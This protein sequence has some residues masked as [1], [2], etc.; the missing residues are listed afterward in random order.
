MQPSTDWKEE[1]A[2]DEAERFE[3]Y[4]KD[5]AAM[6]KRKSQ[7][8]GNGRALHRKQLQALKAT[9]EVLPDLPAPA[10]QGLFA[11]AG[12]HD[13]WV[14]LSNGGADRAPNAKPDIRGFSIKVFGVS[15]PSALGSGDTDHQ[16]FLLINHSAFAFP[17]S[18]EF[19]G[20]ALAASK[21]GTSLLVHLFRRYGL[22]GALRMIGIFAGI[23]GKPFK[24]FACNTFYSAAPIACGPYAVR[25]RLVPARNP[26]PI[27]AGK[28]W[29]DDVSERLANTDLVFDFQLQFFVNEAETPIE[30]ASIDWEESVSPYVTVARLRIP[31]QDL[32][33]A[34]ATAFAEQVEA[35]IFDP[36]GA[37]ME[38]RPLGDVMRARK[39]V[40][41]ASE[42]ERGAL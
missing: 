29:A 9:F 24:G 14:R 20:L 19:V 32:Q 30:N 21:G 26:A 37:L 1:I 17:K 5:F 38:H 23:M 42:K 27:A 18:D 7:K 16:D 12:V 39:V 36:W 11:S 8:Y 41:Y 6:Q 3:R 35:A 15:G 13:A 28:D 22:A 4:A 10:R 2:P 40:Y 33:D 34:N 25:V 31:Q